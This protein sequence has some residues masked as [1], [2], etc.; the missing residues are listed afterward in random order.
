M[1]MLLV[2]SLL[3]GTNPWIGKVAD[4]EADIAIPA[5]PER[6]FSY[7]L[8]LKNLQVIV[9]ADCIGKW[10][11]GDRTFGEGASAIVRY[12]MGAM[13]RRLAMTLT[14]A[15][16][17]TQIDFDH[18]GNKG[19]ITRW[20]LTPEADLTRVTIRTPL[21]QPPWPLRRYYHQEVQPEWQ[22]CYQ[23]TLTNLANEIAR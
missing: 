14:H 1:W 16:A 10:E 5:T 18:L 13:H 21:N 15:L 12:D 4:V 20:M 23:R 7:L 22:L 6:V 2:D 11:L 9:P 19:F 8:D 3:A 17:P